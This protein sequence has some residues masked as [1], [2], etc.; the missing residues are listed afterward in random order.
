MKK[1]QMTLGTF[2]PEPLLQKLPKT[3]GTQKHNT[4]KNNWQATFWLKNQKGFN[5]IGAK[6]G[7]LHI[8]YGKP[9]SD[10]FSLQYSLLFKC[11]CVSQK[12]FY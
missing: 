2:V 10:L 1:T 9:A 12:T 8:N 3:Q 7:H 4:I 11:S 6:V 5:V